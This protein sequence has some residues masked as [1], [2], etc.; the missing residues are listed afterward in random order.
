MKCL[1]LGGGGAV[2]MGLLYQLKS[3]GW[4][5]S[6]VDPRRPKHWA[7]H[8]EKLKGTLLDW[9]EQLLSL[10]DLRA[11][12]MAEDFDAVVDLTPTLDKRRSLLLC[13]EL[14]VSLVNG[15]M[16][17]YKDDIHIAAY[18]FLDDRPKASNCGHMLASGMNPAR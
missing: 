13:D 10:D 14:G 1:V 17:D 5:A 8:Q 9:R 11:R 7:Y 12:L 16:V 4:Q 2:G 6:V 3:F 18:N 15:T